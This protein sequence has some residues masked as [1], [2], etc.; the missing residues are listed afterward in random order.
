MVEQVF[1]CGKS[2]LKTRPIWHKRDD[3]IRGHVFCSFLALVLRH[4]LHWRL[5]QAGNMLEWD[6]VIRDLEA[7]Q[8]TRLTYDAKEFLVRSTAEGTCG[9]V[10]QAAGVALPPTVQR[11]Q[12]RRQRIS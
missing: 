11:I 6:D 1:R 3:T 4:E 10:F 2:L 12:D 8:V 5:R 9:K 7:L